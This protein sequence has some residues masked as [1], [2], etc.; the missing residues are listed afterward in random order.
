MS[1]SG[2]GVILRDAVHHQ[3][4]F[5]KFSLC[6][7]AHRQGYWLREPAEDTGSR[8]MLS[9]WRATAGTLALGT[10]REQ[11]FFQF[12]PVMIPEKGSSQQRAIRSGVFFRR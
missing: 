7:D 8:K 11:M 4:A 10:V 1:P 5:R 3:L 2:S 12:V 9:R 6:S